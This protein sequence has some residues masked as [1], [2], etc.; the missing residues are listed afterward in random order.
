MKVTDEHVHDSK[1]LP[2]LVDDIIKSDS[3]TAIIG[4]LFADG[5]HNNN[6]IFKYLKKKRIQ[7]ALLYDLKI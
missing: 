6:E 7:H 5:G 4:K 3:M 2:E 1:P